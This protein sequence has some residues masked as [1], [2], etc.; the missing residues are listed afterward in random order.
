MNKKTKDFFLGTLPKYIFGIA[1]PLTVGALSALL[2]KDG[3]AL[4]TDL[5]QPPLAPPA[6]VF[7]IVWSIL[8]LLMGISST[9]VFIKREFDVENAEQGLKFYL[10]SLILNF[11][12]SPVFFIRESFLLALVILG[13]PYAVILCTK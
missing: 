9:T 3:M 7:P 1:I 5:A 13:I 2:T 12:W 10:I 11:I 6:I 4:Y 8:Y